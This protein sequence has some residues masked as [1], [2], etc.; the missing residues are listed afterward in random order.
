[1]ELIMKKNILFSLILCAGL[2]L[3]GAIFASQFPK[4]ATGRSAIRGQSLNDWSHAII[5]GLN[6]EEKNSLRA[7]L[8]VEAVERVSCDRECFQQLSAEE[9]RSFYQAKL[10]E[11]IAELRDVFDKEEALELRSSNRGHGGIMV[12]IIARIVGSYESG[13]R[14]S[15]RNVALESI[16]KED[17][18]STFTHNQFRD[19][20]RIKPFV[21]FVVI[22]TIEFFP[23][24][25]ELEILKSFHSLLAKAN[26]NNTKK[27][28]EY[29]KSKIPT[30]SMIK[31]PE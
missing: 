2:L 24:L 10:S 19:L 5:S 21:S 27:L 26:C 30:R 28:L 18:C 22:R 13:K 3:P 4:R 31:M 8:G 9:F 25:S 11:E 14:V 12:N 17:V 7:A 16:F 20:K 23:D 15:L 1:M 6:A 29:V